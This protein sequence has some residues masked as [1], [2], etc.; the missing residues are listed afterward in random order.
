MTNPYG[1]GEPPGG[2]PGG[3]PQYPNA[4]Y[5]ETP[6]YPSVQPGYPTPQPMYDALPPGYPAP[7]PG[8]PAYPQPG[9]PQSGYPAPQPGYPQP[10][11]PAYPQ[12][13]YPQP[14]YGIGGMPLGKN[15]L[16]ITSL[17]LSLI[18]IPGV[19]LC[20][21]GLFL[22]VPAII[23]GGI[24]IGQCKR[25]G[26]DGRGMAVAGVVIGGV[27]LVLEVVYVIA[28]GVTFSHWRDN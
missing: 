14:G 7:Q 26:Q 18:A 1:A 11:Y 17:V 27:A 10:G 15:S 2:A 25:T 23:T 16:A 20:F 8:Y 12:S 5:P 28:V 22:G 9:Y 24:A 3:E 21:F 13:G 4:G 6:Q 19:F